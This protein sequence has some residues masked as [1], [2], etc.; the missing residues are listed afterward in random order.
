MARNQLILPQFGIFAQGS[1]AH[2][3]LEFDVKPDETPEEIVK[4]FRGLRNPGVS[5]GG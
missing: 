3:F 2:Y 4:A 5:A 1:H